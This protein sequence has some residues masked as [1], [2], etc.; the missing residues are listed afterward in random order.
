MD[1]RYAREARCR[2]M[3]PKQI[4][5]CSEIHP[6]NTSSNLSRR[7]LLATVPAKRLMEMTHI[8]RNTMRP[9]DN[10]WMMGRIP[11][12]QGGDRSRFNVATD[13][14]STPLQNRVAAHM[15]QSKSSQALRPT[16][17][18][19]QIPLRE[20]MFYFLFENDLRRNELWMIWKANVWD[21]FP[22]CWHSAGS[23]PNWVS[24]MTPCQKIDAF[25]STPQSG[26]IHLLVLILQLVDHCACLDTEKSTSIHLG[27]SWWLQLPTDC[28]I[29][30]GTYVYYVI[31]Y[32]SIHSVYRE[33][34]KYEYVNIYIWWCIYI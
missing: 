30:L 15:L 28:V 29:F 7:R 19:K 11:F 18:E 16:S 31:F 23:Y 33:A 17:M 4:L 14:S 9:E 25:T 24:F 6:R 5:P 12:F 20:N 27:G 3:L 8:L 34:S 1:R 10:C 32:I 2:P 21:L 13:L 26:F 22:L